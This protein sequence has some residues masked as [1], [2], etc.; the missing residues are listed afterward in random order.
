L[1]LGVYKI[2]KIYIIGILAIILIVAGVIIFNPTSSSLIPNGSN[3]E[4]TINITF[5]GD[6]MLGRDVDDS[7]R[8]NPHPF[9]G[10]ISLLNGTDLTVINLETPLTYSNDKTA[11][12]DITVKTDPQFTYLLSDAGIDVVS[13]ANNHV[14]DFGMSGFLDTLT[15]LQENGIKYVGA[16]NNVEE[17]YKPLIITIK[18]KKIALIAASEFSSTKIPSA[19]ETSP[20]FA[21][22]TYNRVKAAIDEAKDE[23]ADYIICEFHFG[24][25]Y[26]HTPTEFQKNLSHMCIDRGAFMVV[27]HHSHVPQTVENYK[28]KLIFYSLGNCVFDQPFPE[29]QKSMVIV[30]NITDEG[31]LVQ[32]YPIN[33]VNNYPVLM[34]QNNATAFLQDL[35]SYSINVTIDIQNGLG[36]VKTY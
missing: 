21:A 17:A 36:I 28:G 25:E 8:A 31:S 5:T 19:S 27:G 1:K 29:T 14:M 33:L 6:V 34:G 12:K 11:N 2:R 7:L 35:Q 9:A 15:N 26:N 20:G 3:N 32:I 24:D 22:I 16:G 4:N 18:G 10:I 30:L 13:L 23:G